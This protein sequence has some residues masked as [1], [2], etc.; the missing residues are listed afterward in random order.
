LTKSV[1][2]NDAYHLSSKDLPIA[3]IQYIKCAGT[4]VEIGEPAFLLPA[5]YLTQG[6]NKHYEI[7]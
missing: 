4:G 3:D 5:N 7:C 6:Q 1:A 2:I